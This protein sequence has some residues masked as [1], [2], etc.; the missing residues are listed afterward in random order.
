MEEP[1]IIGLGSGD[2][3]LVGDVAAQLEDAWVDPDPFT[4]V[5][6]AL[7]PIV[8]DSVAGMLRW[9]G[10]AGRETPTVPCRLRLPLP[11]PAYATDGRWRKDI[12]YNPR[13]RDPFAGRAISTR[14]IGQLAPDRIDRM[15]EQMGSI[16]VEDIL[17]L[18]VYRGG[19]LVVALG[20]VRLRGGGA[21]TARDRSVLDAL[22]SQ[23]V[24]GLAGVSALE[25]GV[26]R[27]LDIEAVARAA[28]CPAMVISPAGSVLHE[29]AAA[30]VAY[31]RRPDW[32]GRG[33]GWADAIPSWVR[34]VPLR[35]AG[36]RL[37]LLVMDALQVAPDEAAAT[38]WARRWRLPPRYARVAALLLQGYS[39]KDIAGSLGLGL[40]SVRTY[41]K[42][43]LALAGVCSRGELIRAAMA[44]LRDG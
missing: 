28:A 32:L 7:E 18:S 5:A 4:A 31:P 36:Q 42:E 29:T 3:R 33:K 17:R 9:Q 34:R 16:G 6:T 12:L 10:P 27:F 24:D 8:R 13:K 44:T 19:R 30:R 15:M 41:A 2:R 23:L 14:W 40:T 38:P 25:H 35:F 37:T 21:Y 20:H 39:D 11:L 26:L 43:V 22:G 1:R